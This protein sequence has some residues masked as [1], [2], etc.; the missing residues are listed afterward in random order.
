MTDL[1]TTESRQPA[2]IDGD[3]D[4]LIS[5]DDHVLE[6]G[7]V[8]QDRVPAKYKAEAP[9]LVRDRDGEAWVYEGKRMVTPV[10]GAV[11]GKSREEFSF[12]LSAEAI[13]V[14]IRWFGLAIGYALVNLLDRGT[15]EAHAA[16]PDWLSNRHVLN[17]ILTL[18]AAYAIADT[19]Y[20]LRGRVFLSRWPI[21]I[22]VM[23][24]L[25]IGLLCHFDE[26]L[27]SPFRFYYF[28]ALLVCALPV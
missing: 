21:V 5:V 25:F 16:L 13:T 14:R 15:T 4:W 7:H 3:S 6:P 8:W 27:E 20:R 26:G 22:S 18:G 1:E 23:E 19:Y 24:A 9:R 12:E 17:G 2:P 11:A 28:L 10:L